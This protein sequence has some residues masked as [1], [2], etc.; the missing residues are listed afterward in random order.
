MT[1]F[2]ICFVAS[3]WIWC[4]ANSCSQGGP[5]Q[6]EEETEALLGERRQEFKDARRCRLGHFGKG[7]RE[8]FDTVAE[9][10]SLIFRFQILTLLWLMVTNIQRLEVGHAHNRR[11]MFTGGRQNKAPRLSRVSAQQFFRNLRNKFKLW[12]ARLGLLVHPGEGEAPPKK[13]R[14][15]G[16]VAYR[17]F[18]GEWSAFQPGCSPEEL[19]DLVSL[20]IHGSASRVPR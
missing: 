17:I 6:V 14:V 7:L 16:S 8:R 2:R 12:A 4:C 15:R 9:L 18:V 5:H 19:D 10:A 3:R 13:K 20:R 11:Q 1:P